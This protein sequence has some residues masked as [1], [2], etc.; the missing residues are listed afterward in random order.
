MSRRPELLLFGII[1]DGLDIFWCLATAARHYHLSPTATTTLFQL[2]LPF[3]T[4]RTFSI[5]IQPRIV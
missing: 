1:A 3:L 4:N 5:P 2:L